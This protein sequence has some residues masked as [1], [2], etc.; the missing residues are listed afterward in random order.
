[1]P[2]ALSP[3]CWLQ[4]CIK[5]EAQIR[6]F[7][8]YFRG[9]NLQCPVNSLSSCSPYLMG[10]KYC[11]LFLTVILKIIFLSSTL[12]VSS[13]VP[14]GISLAAANMKLTIPLVPE[15]RGVSLRGSP[16][17]SDGSWEPGS[18]LSLSALGFPSLH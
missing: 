10:S 3:V 6:Y 17:C 5:M 11:L 4:E 8:K 9:G 13:K 7:G 15:T 2:W 1:M 14:L 18:A 16:W 12:V